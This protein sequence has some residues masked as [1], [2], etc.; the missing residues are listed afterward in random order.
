MTGH[1][2]G[3]SPASRKD[4]RM[5]TFD[6]PAPIRAAIEV[7]VGDVR[8]TATDRTDTT[9]EV[10]PTDPAAELDLRAAELTQVEFAD[11]RLLVKTPKNLRT[12]GLLR[13][14]GSIDVE[15]A[16]PT[17][18]EVRG[19]AAVAAFH[20][21]GTLGETTIRTGTGDVRLEHTGPLKVT[22]GSGA[23]VVESVTGEARATTASGVIQ[24]GTVSGAVVLKNSNGDSR[25]GAAGGDLHAKAA[26]GH[27][28]VGEAR[29]EVD[30]ASA[31]GDIRIG[32]AHRG[33]VTLRTA[34]GELEVGIALGTAAYLDLHTQFGK[35]INQL[36]SAGAPGPD[37]H[38]V[39]VRAR[40]SFGD[41]IVRRGDA[42]E[43]R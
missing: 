37:E 7:V 23:I 13:K 2:T 4:Q 24:L 35:V 5:P 25:V 17:G 32:A 27:V 41:I 30:A 34:M 14:S 15:I 20:G 12:L 28:V 29:G 36:D 33:S 22:S 18:S 10:R 39:Q 3:V 40:T 38:R 11:G 19:E 43:A 42:G 16:L 1:R 26:N 6:T 8:V 9:V 31:N 21:A